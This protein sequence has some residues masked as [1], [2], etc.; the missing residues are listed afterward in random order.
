MAF[1]AGKSAAAKGRQ[2]VIDLGTGTALTLA[3]KHSN[4]IF[5]CGGA[6]QAITLPNANTLPAGWNV[7]FIVNDQTAAVTITG[8]ADQCM[9]HVITG[10]DNQR[11]QIQPTSAIMFDKIIFTVNVLN[12]D[13]VEIICLDDGFF[14]VRGDCR[15]IDAITCTSP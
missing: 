9:G 3:P 14:H 7:K 6:T 8:V 13:W 4:T 10:G 15:V 12:G 2:K 1:K 5:L 11:R